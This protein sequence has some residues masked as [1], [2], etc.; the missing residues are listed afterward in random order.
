MK[1]LWIILLAAVAIPA[2]SATTVFTPAVI[3]DSDGASVKVLRSNIN[4]NDAV[5]IKTGTIDPSLSPVN[6]LQG[7]LF[8]RAGGSGGSLYIKQD[9]GNTTNWQKFGTTTTAAGFATFGSESSPITISA[10]GGVIPTA[11]IRKLIF[12]RS[13]SGAMVITANPQ[14]APGINIGEELVLIGVSSSNYPILSDGNGVSI[15]GA[16]ALHSNAAI[17]LVWG[18]VTWR[19]IS[20]R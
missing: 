17:T 7:S 4:I 20:R 1:H 12:V 9:T 6:A 11:D 16:V 18:G 14:I 15:N 3:Y 19:E 8:M 13:T 5:D 10:A 2:F